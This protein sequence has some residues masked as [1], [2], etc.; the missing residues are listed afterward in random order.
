MALERETEALYIVVYVVR[1]WRTCFIY[2]HLSYILATEIGSGCFMLFP[3]PVELWGS[4]QNPIRWHVSFYG[5]CS[6]SC[7]PMFF[8][9]T[10]N[11]ACWDR[12][13]CDFPQLDALS[14]AIC[15]MFALLVNHCINMHQS[16]H[17]EGRSY[18]TTKV[19]FWWA[20]PKPV[21]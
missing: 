3:I 4:L 10:L 5:A 19:P 20:F 2:L 16:G 12:W 6:C 7:Q 9:R 14:V 17:I 15:D 18:T 21:G 11:C 8:L 1:V 13:A